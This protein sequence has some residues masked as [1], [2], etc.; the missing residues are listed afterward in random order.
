MKILYIGCVETSRALLKTLL[1]A[2]A[3]VVGVITKEKSDYN[4]DY[5]SLVDFC[6]KYTIDYLYVK[7]VNEHESIRFIKSK[8]PDVIYCFGWS[9][10]V[11]EE[12][13]NIPPKGCI[14][15]HPAALPYN[16]GRHP[17]IWALALGLRETASSFFRMEQ[18][19]DS[20]EILS[21]KKVPIEDSDDARSLYD[22]IMNV[23]VGQVITLTK[24]LENGQAIGQ[25]QLSG[26][27][28]TWRKRNK[29]DGKIDWRMS[30]RAI[31]NL[32]RALTKPYVG[33]H[34]E[35]QNLDYKVWK[36]EEVCWKHVENIE[37]GRVLQVNSFTDFYIKAYDGVI[38]VMDCDDIKLLK[39]DIL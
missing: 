12:I 5:C 1:E 20:G 14:G 22:K 13:L 16:K 19:A 24:Q 2:K 6:E 11:K 7:N 18:D 25:E 38:H 21:Q 37:P 28:N 10:L 33:A 36:V 8:A 35:H 30:A 23:A 27:G 15:F 26:S 4:A 32:V 3:E 17:I 34:F 29:E 31:Y 9:Q 39:G